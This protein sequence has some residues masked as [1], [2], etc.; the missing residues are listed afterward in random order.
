MPSLCAAGA[1]C[2]ENPHGLKPTE[3]QHAALGNSCSPQ[4][5]L[6]SEQGVGWRG[7]PTHVMGDPGL[8]GA[9]SSV[10]PADGFQHLGLCQMYF[11]DGDVEGGKKSRGFS[12]FCF[13]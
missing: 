5:S 2:L 4:G 8:L 9:E 3:H 7:R 13:I 1:K 12:F 10:H 6:E 11:L